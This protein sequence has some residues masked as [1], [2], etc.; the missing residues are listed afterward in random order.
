[1][2]N[3]IP[4]LIA[5]AILLNPKKNRSLWTKFRCLCNQTVFFCLCIDKV[6]R[7]KLIYFVSEKTFRRDR[8][9]SIMNYQKGQP[10]MTSS[11]GNIFHVAGPLCGE[12]TGH[13]GQWRGALA[14]SL[15][16]TW[17]N[18]WVNNREAG[19]LRRHRAHYDIT[20]MLNIGFEPT[21]PWRALPY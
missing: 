16:C 18:G 5:N 6:P 8:D 1:M 4:F 15:I 2:V 17:L 3:W 19:D 21:A 14:F 11:N 9:C 7:V 13:K 20:V 12:F 10:M